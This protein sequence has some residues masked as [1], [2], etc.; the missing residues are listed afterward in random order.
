MSAYN[1]ISLALILIGWAAT[2]GKLCQKLN[3][4]ERRQDTLDNDVKATR[5]WGETEIAKA[6]AERNSNFVRKDVFNAQHAELC[7][8]VREIL[9]LKLPA[10]MSRIETNQ[11]QLSLDIAKL[12][13][14][15]EKISEKFMEIK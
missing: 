6:V 7:A 15:V 11:T 4:M 14:A 13:V 3:E 2:Y 10:F 8:Q 5:A 1:W 9:D 12:Q